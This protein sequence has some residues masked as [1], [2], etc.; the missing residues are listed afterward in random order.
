MM[1]NPQLET[2]ISVVEAGSFSKAADKHLTG[3]RTAMTCSL[4]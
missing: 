3:V 4:L 1:Y 2:F